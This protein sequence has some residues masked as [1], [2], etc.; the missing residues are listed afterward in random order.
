MKKQVYPFISFGEVMSYFIYKNK[1]GFQ[2]FFTY[3]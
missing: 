2:Q 3:S 1:V